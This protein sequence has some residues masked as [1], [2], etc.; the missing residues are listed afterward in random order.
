MIMRKLKK[1]ITLCFGMFL[2]T[3]WTQ[4]TEFP[5]VGDSVVT[6]IVPPSVTKIQ[7]EAWGAQGGGSGSCWLAIQN[8]GGLGGYSS[9]ILSVTPGEA[10]KVLVG[11]KPTAGYDYFD[12]GFNGGGA[13]STFG[14][15]GGG[16]SDVRQ[17]GDSLDFRVIIAGGGGGGNTGCPNHG[18]GGP[19]GGII[20]GDGLSFTWRPPGLGGTDTSGG[21]GGLTGEDGFYGVGG[22]AS[23]GLEGYHIS[24]GGGGYYGGGAAYAA[25]GGGG[26]SYLGGVSDSITEAGVHTGHGEV[27][28]TVLCNALEVVVSDTEICL[29]DTL[30]LNAESLFGAAVFWDGGVVNGIPFVPEDTGIITYT[31]TSADAVDCPFLVDIVVNELPIVGAGAGDEN[32]CEDEP[33]ILASSGNAD[34]YSWSPAD[35]DPGIGTHTYTVTGIIEAT[36]CIATDE[37]ELIVHALPV[38][39]ASVDLDVV[40]IGKPIVLSGG[41]A[42]SYVWNPVEVINGLPYIPEEVGLHTY[43]VIGTDLNDCQNEDSIAV[44]VEDEIGIEYTITD[45]A[46]GMDGSIDITIT[47]G[48]PTYIFDWDNDGVGDF[49]DPEDLDGI[50]SGT[51]IVE[52]EGAT[53][54][55]AYEVITVGSQVGVSEEEQAVVSIYPTPVND[56]LNVVCADKFSFELINLNGQLLLFGSGVDKETINVQDLPNG[57]YLINIIIENEMYTQKIIKI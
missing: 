54:C 23:V 49:D 45:E 7:V 51:Y 10:L 11:G 53:G 22:S 38:V 32:F 57:T 46:L 21:I 2:T 6:Y 39:T 29:G 15:A 18:T 42:T 44:I 37:V 52:V 19:G 12:G 24:G 35:F 17:G 25:G 4:V 8:D 1:L 20:G 16:A 56:Q 28:I 26:S 13:G 31:T 47:G 55:W 43:S 14:G 36:G 48:V 27:I 41:G 3:G 34:S 9:G 5:Y 33:I 40:C 30:I 50:T